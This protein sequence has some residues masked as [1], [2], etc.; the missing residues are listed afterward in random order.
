MNTTTAQ[1]L[2]AFPRTLREL[3]NHRD[4]RN[5]GDTSDDRI[6]DPERMERCNAAAEEGEDGSTHA[7]RLQDMRDNLATM[8]QD[9]TYRSDRTG[10]ILDTIADAIAAEIDA[11]E[12]WHD[13][14]GS[15][16]TSH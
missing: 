6:N 1:R 15:L 10:E 8:R 3:T 13:A 11:A 9:A 7:E 16:H 5:F 2:R 12:A 14:N 4:F